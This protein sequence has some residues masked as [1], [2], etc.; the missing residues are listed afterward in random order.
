MQTQQDF[1][2]AVAKKMLTPA[3]LTKLDDYCKIFLE[4]VETDLTVGNLVW[5][6]GSVAAMGTEKIDFAT[7]PGDWKSPY[8]YLKQEEVLAMVNQYLNPYTEDRTAEDL[9]ILT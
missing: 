6:G 9:N 7:L 8:I 3:S 2:K 4:Y 5:L 1:L